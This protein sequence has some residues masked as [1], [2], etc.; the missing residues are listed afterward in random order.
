MAWISTDVALRPRCSSFG[1]AAW[2]AAILILVALWSP[3]LPA[4]SGDNQC[5]GCHEVERLPIS[6][7]HSFEEWHGSTHGRA[8]VTCEKCHGGDPKLKAADAAHKGVHPASNTESL[9]HPKRLPA[10]CGTCHAKELAAYSGTVHA[11][12]LQERGQGANCFTCH[13]SMAASLPSPAQ[14]S[15][16]CAVCHKQ[17]VKAR[18]AL[19]M[20]AAVKLQ[21]HKTKRTVDAARTADPKWHAGAIERLHE[22]ERVYFEVQVKWHRFDMDAGLKESGDLLKLGK[23]LDEEGRVRIRRAD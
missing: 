9:V 1:R 22:I 14:M 7:G 8:G 18:A 21:L 15:E 10:T 17:P 4:A 19:S 16:R 6:L 3:P 2:S 20:L 13:G 12:N 11:K 23:L 5:V